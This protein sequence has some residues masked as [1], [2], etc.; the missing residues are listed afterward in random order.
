MLEDLGEFATLVALDQFPYRRDA[1]GLEF[2]IGSVVHIVERADLRVATDILIIRPRPLEAVV[3][4]DEDGVET[5][6]RKV[7]GNLAHAVAES[8]T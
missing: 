4:I 3:A 1:A 7:V 8:S 5:L 2:A 6:V